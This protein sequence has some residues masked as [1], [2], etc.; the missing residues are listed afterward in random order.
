MLVSLPKLALG[1]KMHGNIRFRILEK[2][3]HTTQL[4]E[5]A[6]FQHLITARNFHII[7]PDGEDGWRELIPLCREYSKT[8]AHPE[9]QALCAIVAGKLLDQSLKFIL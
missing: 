6:L 2:E 8:R 5:K 3:V 1:N 4:C 9:A 7:K